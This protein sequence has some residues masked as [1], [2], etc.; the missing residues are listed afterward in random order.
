M[1]EKNV[2]QKTFVLFHYHFI[3]NFIDHTYM[4]NDYHSFSYMDINISSGQFMLDNLF[5]LRTLKLH[6]CIIYSVYIHQN[7]IETLN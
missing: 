5:P 4:F 3:C 2:T 1:V 7:A 6:K